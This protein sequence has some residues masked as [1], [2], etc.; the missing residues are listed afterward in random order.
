L[1][2]PIQFLYKLGPFLAPAR[3]PP[4]GPAPRG[5]LPY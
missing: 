2:F 3:V 4:F 1:S 5:Q